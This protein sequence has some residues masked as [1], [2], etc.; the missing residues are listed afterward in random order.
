MIRDMFHGNQK[1]IASLIVA[2]SSPRSQR[3]SGLG[4]E[5]LAAAN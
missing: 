3:P 1:E 4:Q 5:T 2:R